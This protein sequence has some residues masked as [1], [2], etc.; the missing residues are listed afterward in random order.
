M[1]PLLV[2]KLKMTL[3]RTQSW[4]TSFTMT[5]SRLRIS[6]AAE[7]DTQKVQRLL[8]FQILSTFPYDQDNRR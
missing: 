5:R 6:L 8:Q 7:G 3:C 4:R 1:A 2:E